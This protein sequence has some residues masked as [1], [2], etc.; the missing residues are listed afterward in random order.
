[1]KKILFFGAGNIAQALIFGLILSGFDKK[2]ILFIDRNTNNKK[3]LKKIGIREYSKKQNNEI[4]LFILAVKPKDALAAFAEICSNFKKTKIISLVAGIKS[5]QYLSID[6]NI[7]FIRAMPNTSSQYNKGIT[8]IFNS[9]ATNSTLSKVK[10]IFK[11][12]GII[13]ELNK[14]GDMD[15]FTGLIG[16][17][18]AYFFYLQKVYE[19]R[20][21]KLCDGDSKMSKDIIGNFVEGVGISSKGSLTLDELISTVAS[22]KGTTEAGLDNFK[23][24]KLLKSFDKGIIAA[25][26]RSKEISNE[27]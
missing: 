24:T 12:V 14:E 2:N 11:K 18:P 7:E 25:I 22:K 27:S 10:K 21:M 3:A 5:K 13:L 8:A 16:S 19:K 20:I 6:N 1:M 9:S 15:D 26:N 17:G 23:S 4:D